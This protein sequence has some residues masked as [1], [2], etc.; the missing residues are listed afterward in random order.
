M[1]AAAILQATK[2]MARFSIER[3][4]GYS[5]RW[6]PMT[7]D[8]G[9]SITIVG[10]VSNWSCSSQLTEGTEGNN[11]MKQTKPATAGMAQ[12]SLLISVLDRP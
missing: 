5:L 8:P 2:L 9:A 12:S 11:E 7:K 6:A 10:T 1:A 3:T 4:A